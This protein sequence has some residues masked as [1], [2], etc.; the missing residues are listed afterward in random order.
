MGIFGDDDD[1]ADS[2]V[3][4]E[5]SRKQKAGSY[6]AYHARKQLAFG[7]LAPSLLVLH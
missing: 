6:I 2:E 7:T 3:E 5:F 4:A 1:E